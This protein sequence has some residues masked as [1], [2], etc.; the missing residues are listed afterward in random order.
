MGVLVPNTQ[1]PFPNIILTPDLKDCAGPYLDRC[2]KAS[3]LEAS[4]KAIYHTMV[5]TL[6]R[7]RL[8]GRPDTQWR[9]HLGLGDLALAWSSFYK[10]PL[11]KIPADPRS[12]VLHGAV[13][14]NSF[15]SV[16]NQDKCLFCAQ[17]EPVFVSVLFVV[18]NTPTREKRED[19]C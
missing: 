2:P 7:D 1:D 11:T 13:E 17:R 18:L 16:I 9:Q 3:L 12:R 4:G 5:K 19:S 14:V 6:N 10:P 15:K 8:S